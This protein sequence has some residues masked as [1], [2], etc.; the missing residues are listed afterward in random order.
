MIC[1]KLLCG[2]HVLVKCLQ[3]PFPISKTTGHRTFQPVTA[4]TNQTIPVELTFACA[5]SASSWNPM[6]RRKK[7]PDLKVGD[8]VYYDHRETGW[9]LVK[10]L[11]VDHEGTHDGGA[12]YVVGG[13]AQL[14]GAEIETLRSRLF[15]SMPVRQPDGTYKPEN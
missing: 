15:K 7:A 4:I 3:L 6:A 1:Y 2:Y 13:A 14:K 11:K 8:I 5:A 12:T 9:L 10:V